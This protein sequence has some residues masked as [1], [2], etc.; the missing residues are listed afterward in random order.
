M[1]D[2]WKG[3][4]DEFNAVF[5]ND[6]TLF[7]ALK[8]V[9]APG[10][11][12]PTLDYGQLIPVR[13]ELRTGFDYMYQPEN[14]KTPLK[15]ET[16]L[17]DPDKPDGVEIEYFSDITWKPET[18]LCVLDGELG[19]KPKKIR[20]FGITNKIKAWQYGM[21]KRREIRYRRTKYSFSTEMDA[22]NSSY[23]SYDVL[24]DDILGYSQTGHV[25]GVQGR[26]LALSEP[27]KWGIGTRFIS[28]RKPNGTLSGPYTCTAGT[29]EDSVIVNSDLDFIPDCSG[30]MELSIFQFGTAIRW[31]LPSLVTNIKP[32]GTD[33][34]IVTVVNYD[35]RVYADDD[36][37]PPE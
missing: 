4:A 13:D 11:S 21:R 20:A 36:L 29:T 25:L 7:N 33:K 19:I 24:A 31:C 1:Q 17:F 9:L 26:E 32:S 3:R 2:V 5:D 35:E 8:R 6:S 14:M 16:K 23:L 10:F 12:E 34:V 28:L 22:L 37:L 15:R 27:L 30:K 18:I